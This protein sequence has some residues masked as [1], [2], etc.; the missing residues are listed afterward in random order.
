MRRS[1]QWLKLKG[2]LSDEFVIG[3][4]T[5]GKGVREKA[6]GSVI[7]GQYEE[8]KLRYVGHAGSGFDEKTLVTLHERLKTLRTD[9]TPFEAEVPTMGRWTRPGTGFRRS[10]MPPRRTC[11]K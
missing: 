10:N 3:G 6:I 8:G 2:T 11:E 9:E 1:S 4:Y 5:A 7:L